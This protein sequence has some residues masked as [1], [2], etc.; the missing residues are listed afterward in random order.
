MEGD[1]MLLVCGFQVSTM[2]VLCGSGRTFGDLSDSLHDRTVVP[3]HLFY[4]VVEGARA[5][6]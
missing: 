1:A 5:R 3:V 2:V 6:A 4:L